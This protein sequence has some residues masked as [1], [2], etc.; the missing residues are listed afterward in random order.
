MGSEELNPYKQ[1]DLESITS[2]WFLIAVKSALTIN[3][4][5]PSTILSDVRFAMMHACRVRAIDLVL[6]MTV[7][8][9][10]DRNSSPNLLFSAYRLAN[11]S[12]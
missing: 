2:V 11:V 6:W 10:D 8:T 12:V 1:F 4:A 7:S 5:V 9:I 3:F